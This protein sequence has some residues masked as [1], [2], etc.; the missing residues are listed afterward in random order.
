MHWLHVNSGL[1]WLAKH[2]CQRQLHAQ[3]TRVSSKQVLPFA[4]RF[5]LSPCRRRWAF[6]CILHSR[7]CQVWVWSAAHECGRCSSVL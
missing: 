6:D 7:V 4:D 3:P 2:A 1:C 5:C